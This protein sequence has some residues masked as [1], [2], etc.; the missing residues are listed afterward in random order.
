VRGIAGVLAVL[1]ATNASAS[2]HT[3]AECFEGSDFI[4]NAALARENG[5]RRDVF[6]A[7]MEEDFVVIQAFPPAL[8]WF[9]RDDEDEDFLLRYAR[10]VFDAPLSP[11]GH[12][13][14]FLAACFARA[15]V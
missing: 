4:A 11:E 7:R 13:A 6:L 14:R 12:R 1:L 3:V 5:V 2:L 9:A 8:R 15:T 10:E